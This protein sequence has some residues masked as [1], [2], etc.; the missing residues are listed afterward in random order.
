MK[1]R[2]T[3]ITVETYEVLVISRHGSVSRSWCASCGQEVAAISLDDACNSGLSIEAI[4]R[5][6]E[7]GRIHL[8]E[9]SGGSSLICL[10]SLIQI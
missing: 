9:T 8:V 2:R 1:N 4:Q 10:N 5:E 7:A 3:E 6:V